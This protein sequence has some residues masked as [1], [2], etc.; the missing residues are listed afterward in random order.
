MQVLMLEAYNRFSYEDMADPEFGAEDVL[1]RVKACGIC[2]S[3]IHGMDGSSGRRQPPIV[4]GHEAS[5][6]IAEV[7]SAV[8][9]W[10]PG[11]RV[12]FDSMM[13]CGRCG[14]CRQGKINLCDNRR[15]LGVSCGEYR[16]HGA[17]A[18]YV[19]V[20]Q[21]GVYRL[22]GTL[23]F[24][25]AALVEPLSVAVHAIGRTPLALNDTAVVV[26]TG[27]V[28]L[29]VVQ[30][31]RVAGCGEIVAV[32]IDRGRLDLACQLGA[33]LALRADRDDV[34]AAV[35]E[36]TEGRGADVVVEVVGHTE[37]VKTAVAVVKKGGHVTVVGNL[38]PTIEL[39]L[40]SI[41]TR[42][43]SMIGTC[44]SCGEYPA[45]LEMMSRG[46]IQVEPLISTTAPLSEGAQWFDR[47]SRP[48][49]GLLKVVLI[50]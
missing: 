37:T 30:A 3:D 21:R 38:S 40:Q 15:V 35:Q 13:S 39:P 46:S 16:C 29:L 9:Q 7:G 22:P 8:T 31:L 34:L 47:L 27:M 24:E 45:C 43:V 32:D 50:P 42:E 49:S 11:D 17:F 19:V 12:T 4:M 28:G 2:G 23:P 44:G 5:G 33:T 6:V 1:V 18:E 48:D 41:V 20:P 36:K 10:E 14:F 26:G 25:H